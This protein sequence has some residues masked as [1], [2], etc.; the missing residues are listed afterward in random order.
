MIEDGRLE[1]RYISYQNNRL[2]S[3]LYIAD[4]AVTIG[5]SNFSFAG[6]RHQLEANARFQHQK[7]PKRYR[8]VKQLA[9]NYW[10]LADN[11]NLDLLDLL[12]Q[13]LRVVTW[14]EALGRMAGAAKA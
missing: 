14:Q 8:E 6:M 7:E 3:K 12:N 2:H 13:L 9:E 10:K 5:S 11:Y 1:S 4:E